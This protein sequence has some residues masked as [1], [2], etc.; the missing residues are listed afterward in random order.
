MFDLSKGLYA[1]MRNLT[2]VLTLALFAAGCSR[3]S[4]PENAGQGTVAKSAMQLDEWSWLPMTPTHDEEVS[5][6]PKDAAI[7]FSIPEN[8]PV[9]TDSGGGWGGISS[10]GEFVPRDKKSYF[11]RGGALVSMVGPVKRK[12][13][14]GDWDFVYADADLKQHAG[15]GNALTSGE[16]IL[17][18]NQFL[19]IP[20][21]KFVQNSFEIES[22]GDRFVL[23]RL[24]PAK[25]HKLVFL[26]SGDSQIPTAGYI[27]SKAEVGGEILERKSDG[28]YAGTTRRSK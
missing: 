21:D 15:W 18:R 25:G 4:G 3:S 23:I 28:W 1:L 24:D 20:A 11:V 10:S 2:L 6:I 16:L 12:A 5:K 8:E 7:N 22:F 26:K 14:W 17:P 19:N 13:K 27:G 9:R